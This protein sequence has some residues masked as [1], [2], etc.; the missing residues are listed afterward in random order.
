MTKNEILKN[1]VE[2][3]HF[4]YNKGLTPGKS[5]NISCRF[6]EEGISKVA[7]TKSGI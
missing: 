5:G 4:I 7:I 1:L 2:I 6:Y 3:S